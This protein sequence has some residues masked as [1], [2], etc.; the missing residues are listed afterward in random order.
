MRQAAKQTL[1]TEIMTS[2]SG[3]T[4]AEADPGARARRDLVHALFSHNDF[5]TVH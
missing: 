4:P 1:S 2:P 5:I 3:S